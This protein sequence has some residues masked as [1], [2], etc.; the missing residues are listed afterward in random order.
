MITLHPIIPTSAREHPIFGKGRCLEVLDMYETFYARI[1]D[2]A[3]GLGYF[4]LRDEQVVGTCGFAGQPAEGCVE[5]AYWTF[6]EFEGQGIAFAAS[7]ALIRITRAADPALAITANGDRL[8]LRRAQPSRRRP[9]R[10]RMP[11]RASWKSMVSRARASYRTMRSAMPGCGAWTRDATDGPK[12]SAAMRG[13]IR[14]VSPL[15]LFFRDKCRL[16]CTPVFVC[17]S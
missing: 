4:I 7:G 9:R 13:V 15:A 12:S 11:P 5:I 1:G 6:P 8:H 16:P 10:S 3:P 17:S 14:Q 2:S